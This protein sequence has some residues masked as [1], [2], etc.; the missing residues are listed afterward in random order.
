MSVVC[1]RFF[2][3]GGDEPVVSA[4]LACAPGISDWI[5]F[6]DEP[7]LPERAYFVEQVVHHIT[8]KQIPRQHQVN[9]FLRR[10]P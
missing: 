2:V 1:A 3:D 8:G 4:F 5:S 9:V 6:P 10:L 7:A